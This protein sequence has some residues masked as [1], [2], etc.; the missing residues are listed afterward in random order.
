MDQVQRVYNALKHAAE[1]VGIANYRAGLY[2]GTY[3]KG[4]LVRGY[5]ITQEHADL[6]E[7]MDKVSRGTMTPEE[8]MALVNSYDVMQ[9][10]FP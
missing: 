10:R 1:Q 9:Q 6:V 8:G 2:K 5:S 4:K 3:R 7:A